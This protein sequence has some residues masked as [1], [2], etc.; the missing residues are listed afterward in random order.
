[1]KHFRYASAP[2]LAGLVLSACSGCKGPGTLEHETT[3]SPSSGT[4]SPATETPPEV[5]S[6]DGPINTDTGLG[7]DWHKKGVFMEIYVRA[8]KD[9]D[10]DGTGDFKGLTQSLDYLHDLGITGLWLMP[11]TKSCDHDHGYAV[12]DYRQVEPDYGTLADFD[13]LLAEAHKR[14]IG[15]I[16]DY[17]MNHGGRES[18]TFQD[19]AR[20]ADSPY[21]SWYVWE[22]IKPSGWTNWSGANTWNANPY[23]GPGYYYSVFWEGMPDFNLKNADTVAYHKENLKFWLSRGVDGIRFDAVEVLLERDSANYNQLPESYA[24]MKQMRDLCDEY[25]NRY[26]VCEAPGAPDAAAVSASCRSAFAFN[27]SSTLKQAAKGVGAADAIAGFPY[28]HPMASLA[29]LLSNHDS[30]AGDRPYTEFNGNEQQYKLAAATQ[31]TLP[32]IPFIYY[33]EEVGMSNTTAYGDQDAKLRTPMSWSADA[34]T[35]GFTTGTPFRKPADNIATHNVAVEQ[36]KPGSLLAFYKTLINLR[37]SDPALSMGLYQMI[38]VGTSTG[39]QLAFVRRYGEKAT[40]VVINYENTAV[41]LSLSLGQ[42]FAGATFDRVYPEGPGSASADAQGTLVASTPAAGILIYRTSVGVNEP[43]LGAE[44]FVRG[45]MN[46][47]SA[48]DR[49]SYLQA[50][51]YQASINL[52]ARAE[53]Y[54]FK[55]ADAGWTY[56]NFGPIQ[57]ETVTPGKPLQL[58]QTGWNNGGVGHDLKL[59]VTQDGSYLIKLDARDPLNPKLTVTRM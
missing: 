57:G 28:S 49:L 45:D 38:P 35:A 1:M 16:I 54:L 15:V 3:G 22:D 47:W 21:R 6:P 58:E 53:P 48:T 5:D 31:L 20:S 46:D 8:F 24:F 11:M 37:K 30:F 25:P 34:T 36:G 59:A 29:T 7:A 2:L 18:A 32:G 17:V 43:Y 50:N 10:G 19:S 26:M 33:G 39:N 4:D 23:G 41:S 56:Y 27:L 14:G 55:I 44:L 52:K 42:D 13:E 9:S 51:T 12:C 40:L